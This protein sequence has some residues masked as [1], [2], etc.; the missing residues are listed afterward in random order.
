M[1]AEYELWYRDAREVVHQILAN[2]EFASGIDYVPYHEFE[3]DKRRYCDLMSGN[4]AWRQCVCNFSLLVLI[5][6]D[7][8]LRT[9]SLTI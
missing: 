7:P 2:P 6:T 5:T 9:L 4:W 1:T 3:G 8:S